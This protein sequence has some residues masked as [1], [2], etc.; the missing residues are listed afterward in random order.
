MIEA[1][2]NAQEFC[3]RIL[4]REIGRHGVHAAFAYEDAADAINIMFL[5]SGPSEEIQKKIGIFGDKDKINFGRAEKQ[6]NEIGAIIL[7]N[8][9]IGKFLIDRN[10][11]EYFADYYGKEPDS[12]ATIER[13][14]YDVWAYVSRKF[15]H[16]G[17]K[18]VVTA[19]CGAD[20]RRVFRKH[21][22]HEM[23]RDSSPET[24]NGRFIQPIKDI[25]KASGDYVAF[26][27]IC[28][29]E[30]DMARTHAHKENTED[31]WEDFRARLKFFRMEC[32]ETAITLKK[33]G[34]RNL[35]SV[36]AERSAFAVG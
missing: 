2:L 22:I 11:K 12:G 4:Q 36:R 25:Y 24:I 29:M 30:L 15:M 28:R 1:G 13:A 21:E 23:V 14:E 10:L 31:A 26:R 19:V 33:I 34:Q 16:A 7:E 6:A 17:F 35:V 5:F 9:K 32:R 3:E 18:E 8:T 20:P 27:E